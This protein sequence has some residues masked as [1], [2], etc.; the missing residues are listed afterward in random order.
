MFPVYVVENA[1][2]RSLA[3]RRRRSAQWIVKTGARLARLD[4]DRRSYWLSGIGSIEFA[5]CLRGLVF[6]TRANSQVVPRREHRTSASLSLAPTPDRKRNAW[7]RPMF[8]NVPRKRDTVLSWKMQLESLRNVNQTC[9]VEPDDSREFSK[10]HRQEI[11]DLSGDD[12]AICL[13]IS[14][15]KHRIEETR[16]AQTPSGRPR[17]GPLRPGSVRIAKTPSGPWPLSWQSRPFVRW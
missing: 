5:R 13:E 11:H 10:K 15:E 7:I 4:I 1:A 9:I 2:V 6:A 12:Q 17:S 8:I 14:G 16:R 3:R